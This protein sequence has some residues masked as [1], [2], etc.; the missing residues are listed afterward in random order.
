MADYFPLIRRAIEALPEGGTSE[1]RQAIYERAARCVDA[2]IALGRACAAGDRISSG[3]GFSSKTPSRGSRPISRKRRRTNSTLSPSRLLPRAGPRLRRRR[4]NAPAGPARYRPMTMP[5]QMLRPA[6]GHAFPSRASGAG[7]AEAPQLYRH[8]H[9][10]RPADHHRHRGCGLYSPR[11]PDRFKTT[12]QAAQGTAASSA[13]GAC[14][15][16]LAPDTAF[17]ARPARNSARAGYSRG[18]A[19]L[20]LRGKC[21]QSATAAGAARR[22]RLARRTRFDRGARRPRSASRATSKFQ[23][24]G[25]MWS[26][27]FAGTSIRPF[28]PPTRSI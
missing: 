12:L 18:C 19:R 7:A 21:L 20:A 6:D 11:P 17:A 24:S 9:R 22:R 2:P 14:Q 4:R 1:Q 3:N 8:H 27:S 10:C 23:M 5:Q 13:N 26:S 16:A 25:S 15:Y 28:Q